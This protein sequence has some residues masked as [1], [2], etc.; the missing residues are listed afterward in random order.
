MALT[1]SILFSAEASHVA[2]NPVFQFKVALI[3][4]G[5]LNIGYFEFFVKSRVANLSPLKPLP[6]EARFAGIASLTIWL[7]VAACGRSIAYF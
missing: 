7:L 6:S 2:L 5:L 3:V 4:L 1:G